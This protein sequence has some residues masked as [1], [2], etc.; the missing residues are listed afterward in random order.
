MR[1]SPACS[2]VLALLALLSCPALAGATG[3][4]ARL[5]TT[6]GDNGTATVDLGVLHKGGGSV[7]P[8]R[9][10]PDGSIYTFAA[11]DN[12]NDTIRL[13][14]QGQ[15]DTSF[16]PSGRRNLLGLHLRG[17]DNK[18]R[19]L[20]TGGRGGNG[21]VMRRLPDGTL[22]TSFGVGGEVTFPGPATDR[23]LVEPDNSMIVWTGYSQ[24]VA[25]TATGAVRSTFGSHGFVTLPVTAGSDDDI[26]T[27]PD[28]NLLLAT[29][30]G[31]PDLHVSEWAANGSGAVPGFGNAGTF[32]IPEEGL[33]GG[34][35]AQFA[36]GDVV[37]TG[38]SFNSGTQVGG[39]LWAARVDATTG[40][41]DTAWGDQG[42][43]GSPG[44]SMHGTGAPT[45]DAAGGVWVV[46]AGTVFRLAPN[47]L[48]DPDF[49]DAGLIGLG[50]AADGGGS[51]VDAYG[52]VVVSQIENTTDGHLKI[53]LRRLRTDAADVSVSAGG[54]SG[55]SQ[56]KPL[57]VKVRARGPRAAGSVRV[58]ITV[59]KARLRPRTL[60]RAGCTLSASHRMAR[61]SLTRMHVVDVRTLAVVLTGAR[62]GARVTVTARGP[63]PDDVPKN[64]RL[65]RSVG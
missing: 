7:A 15:L 27:A 29:P 46:G 8:V 62:R 2:V 31:N 55:G 1:P 48:P 65:H 51:D 41:L 28:G 58:V 12:D 9:I 43:A 21:V 52:R 25:L 24:M 60:T 37:L 54:G 6:F 61:C 33:D 19:L 3:I 47:G 45:V 35:D 5:D 42:I 32:T 53:F 57:L 18:G 16:G 34:G 22:D 13:T 20:F 50:G 36:N 14:P 40:A 26:L 64:N 39:P 4:D 56:L 10:G 17:F 30:G 59:T 44:V 11:Y 38:A 23:L 49:G 63:R